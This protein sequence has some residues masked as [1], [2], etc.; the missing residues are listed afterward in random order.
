[1][2]DEL[3]DLLRELKTTRL[4]L[5]DY[6]DVKK[7][8]LA[9]AT[10][11]PEYTAAVG[12]IAD[13]Q[14][15]IEYL[16]SKI[17]DKSLEIYKL[18]KVKQVHPFVTVKVFTLT[19]VSYIKQRAHEWALTHNTAVLDLNT[20]EFDKIVVAGKVPPEIATFTSV[21]DPRPQIAQSL[22]KLE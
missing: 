4:V 6:Q 5:E 16:E 14:A 19:T 2:M 20:K 3:T 7:T 10:N 8:I 12:A 1:M 15:R 9:N 18:E 17:K 13:T 21:D 11:R 22:E